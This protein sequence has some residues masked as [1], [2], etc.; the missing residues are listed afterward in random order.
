MKYRLSWLET[1]STKH[2]VREPNVTVEYSEDGGGWW[3]HEFSYVFEA[4]T[5]ITAKK[6]AKT[7]VE[8][9]SEFTFEVWSLYNDKNEPI[10]T[11][12]DL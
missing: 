7:F 6:I 12:E 2:E 11:E 1:W 3:E 5:E 8:T 9:K 10:L 4:P